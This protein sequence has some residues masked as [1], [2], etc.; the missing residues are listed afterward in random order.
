[1]QTFRR[2]S[3]PSA[4]KWKVCWGE[5]RGLASVV[6]YAIFLKTL[7]KV[8]TKFG[9]WDLHFM[10]SNPLNFYSYRS[11]EILTFR[12]AKIE[13]YPFSHRWLN[14]KT[15]DLFTL[16]LWRQRQYVPPKRLWTYTWLYDVTS[17]MILLFKNE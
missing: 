8:F 1:M 13:Y 12:E 4:W 15:K 3:A 6:P 16:Q 10:L 5:R 14:V 7:K 2:F 17:H 9:I 11:N